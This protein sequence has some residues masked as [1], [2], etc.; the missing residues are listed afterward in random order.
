MAARKEGL[1]DSLSHFLPH[2][3]LSHS[4]CLG[5]VNRIPN[6][7]ND[8]GK[9]H[10]AVLRLPETDAVKVISCIQEVRCPRQMIP[11]QLRTGTHINLSDACRSKCIDHCSMCEDAASQRLKLLRDISSDL[12]CFPKSYK[13]SDVSKGDEISSGGEARLYVSSYR[14]RTVVIRRFHTK[15]ARDQKRLTKV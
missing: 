15:T 1:C 14:D 8:M 4:A 5:G 3:E 12:G 7:M 9:F 2:L 6:V 13:I 11:P 10:L